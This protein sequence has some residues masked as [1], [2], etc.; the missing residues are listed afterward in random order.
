MSD[1]IPIKVGDILSVE[2]YDGLPKDYSGYFQTL[3][4]DVWYIQN[5]RVI[6]LEIP[7]NC[8]IN[9]LPF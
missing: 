3:E 9:E 2:K 6:R 1:F 8:I 4:G 5:G 7:R